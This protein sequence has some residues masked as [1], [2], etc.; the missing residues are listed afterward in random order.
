[1]TR[2]RYFTCDVFTDR[3]FCGNPLARPSTTGCRTD[4]PTP[5]LSRPTASSP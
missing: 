2:H 3:A 4:G 1:M 5:G